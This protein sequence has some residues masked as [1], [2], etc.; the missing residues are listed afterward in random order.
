MNHSLDGKVAVSTG[1]TQGIGLAIAQEFVKDGATVVVTGRDQGRLDEAVA[2]IGPTA[3]GGRAD[4]GSPAEMDALLKNVKA[5]HGRLD[6]VVANA[7]VDAGAGRYDRCQMQETAA[8]CLR[9][10]GGG[11]DGVPISRLTRVVGDAPS[12]F[13]VP[14]SGS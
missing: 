10:A 6:V 3:S 1:G 8:R 11:V 14:T 12:G 9:S 13:T 7:V 5:R 4:A 2:M